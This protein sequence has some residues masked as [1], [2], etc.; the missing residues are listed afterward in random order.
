MEET[1]EEAPAEEEAQSEIDVLKGAIT[2]LLAQ[3][4]SDVD[5]S[6]EDLKTELSA[7]KV[8]TESKI[9][10]LETELDKQ[11]EV[12]AIVANPESKDVQVEL[13]S[14]KS[15]KARVLANIAALN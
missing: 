9:E 2:E 5:K 6:I 7:D 1:T 15:I 11:P 14:P 13:K 8:E 12:E 3:F 4:K 10:E